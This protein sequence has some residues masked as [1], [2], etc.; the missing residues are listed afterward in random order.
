MRNFTLA[1]GAK[2]P[3]IGLGTWD[4]DDSKVA[5][6]VVN[7]LHLGYRHIDTA[8]GYHNERGVGEGVRE[9]MRKF[10]ISRDEIFVTT[11]LDARHKDY[12]GAKEAIEA[13][14]KAL[15][16]GHIDLMLIHSPKPWDKFH[17]DERYFE[18]N[19]QAWRALS[20]RVQS[21]DIRAIGVSNFDEID[22][23]NIA[24][25]A[26]VRPAVNQIL[27][28]IGNTPFELVQKC[29]D[30][31]VVAQ[32]YSPMAHGEIFRSREIAR[33]AAEMGVSVARLCIAYCLNLGMVVLPKS[34]DS[35][36]MSENLQS[37]I[38]INASDLAVLRG[39][40]FEDYGK[41]GIYPVFGKNY[42][43]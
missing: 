8:Q 42:K 14:L 5:D 9:G 36:R 27:A 17:G 18:G 29:T 38:A 41:S 32:A 26:T 23:A 31:G 10:G 40:V 43:G 1:N 4:I 22:L 7:A 3:A 11:K 12:A 16:L 20:Q 39:L 13:S 25:N 28:H 15:N 2:L 37:D 24:D 21:G 30:M 34:S 35:T 19:L 6:V 33:I